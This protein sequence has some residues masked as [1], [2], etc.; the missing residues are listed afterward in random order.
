[1]KLVS[2]ISASDPALRNTPLEDALRDLGLRDLLQEC[3]ALDEFRRN[4]NNLYERVRALFFL[5]AI[6]RYALPAV[7]GIG[8]E[9]QVPF[10]GYTH[11]LERRFE[12]AIRHFLKAQ[13]DRG[14][15]RA[16]SSALAL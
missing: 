1:M 12:E 11:F 2:I 3:S 8:A 15:N 14:P 16:L 5:S 10:A 9:G 7:E 13:V 6:H 4:S